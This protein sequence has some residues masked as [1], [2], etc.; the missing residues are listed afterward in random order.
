MATGTINGVKY[1]T[2]ANY[3]T[4]GNRWLQFKYSTSIVSPGKTKVTWTLK[5]MYDGSTS[6]RSLLTNYALRINGEV[7]CTI[8]QANRRYVSYNNGNDYSGQLGEPVNE[9][10][11]FTVTHN[12]SGEGKFTIK[13]T[14]AI[15]SSTSQEVSKTI[16]LPTNYPYTACGAPTSIKI[17][18]DETDITSGYFNTATTS[19]TLS[20]S[21]AKAG[22]ANSIK[23]YKVYYTVNGTPTL[24]SSSVTVNSTS[25]EGS[26]TITLPENMKNGQ[27]IKFAIITLGSAGGDYN[28]GFSSSK[29]SATKNTPPS[30]P[31]ISVN[32]SIVP[33]SGGTVTFTIKAG[34]D[35]QGHS[36]KLYYSTSSNESGIE[37]SGSLTTSTITESITYY[38]WSNDGYDNS[39]KVSKTITINTKPTIEIIQD[40]TGDVYDS[41]N[42]ET[43]ISYF[44]GTIQSNKISGVNYKWEIIKDGITTQIGTNSTIAFKPWTKGIKPGE[45]YQVKATINDG[46]ESNSVIT[47]ETFTIPANASVKYVYN[48]WDG[49]S[50][51]DGTNGNMFSTKLKV[52]LPNDTVFQ[53]ASNISIAITADNYI[54][55]ASYSQDIC[56]ITLPTN[57]TPGK[58]YNFKLTLSNNEGL[59]REY[60]F[61]KTKT[62]SF[63]GGDLQIGNNEIKIFPPLQTTTLNFSIPNPEYTY[64]DTSYNYNLK[65]SGMVLYFNNNYNYPYSIIP[66]S[67]LDTLIFNFTPEDWKNIANEIGIIDN[68][69]NIQIPLEL[70]I[71]N[72]FEDTVSYFG[73]CIFNMQSKVN[74]NSFNVNLNNEV[75]DGN[76]TSIREG[77]IFNW[78][79]N[80][81]SYNKQSIKSEIFICRKNEN[82]QPVEDDNNWVLYI[83]QQDSLVERDNTYLINSE[84]TQ[85]YTI[86]EISTSNYIFF[87]LRII[88]TYG[89]ITEEIIE[90]GRSNRHIKPQFTIENITYSENE[91]YFN[92][93]LIDNGGGI[94]GNSL[95]NLKNSIELEKENE[96]EDGVI[97]DLSPEELNFSSTSQE[98][99]TNITNFESTVLHL[100]LKLKTWLEIEDS[101]NSKIFKEQTYSFIVYNTAPTIA[102]RKN[103]V[104]INQKTFGDDEVVVISATQERYNFILK[105]AD[106]TITINL[107]NGSIT[108]AEITGAIIN[109][110]VIDGGTW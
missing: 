40:I 55:V 37:F 33:S 58:E 21:G 110:C 25:T 53:E 95:S 45:S 57:L 15:Y 4:S 19:L 83:S 6:V 42:G 32:K 31:T 35:A 43:F 2:S 48:Q 56:Y 85:S 75:L 9:S 107:K 54:G 41:Y 79:Y 16:T 3:S 81:S 59:T 99:L 100:Q 61:S 69:N 27:Y 106:K 52:G 96:N 11:S 50:N 51:I 98:I 14:S 7:K 5:S 80:L 84:K 66:E 10:G 89:Q 13:L 76:S 77:Q 70:R 17:L 104:G 63:P 49:N 109:N 64:G 1:N 20:W 73:N 46:I 67:T 72:L 30:A 91:L 105:G 101:E 94:I 93:N 29:P 65:E 24:S 47:E 92:I 90:A 102:V 26:T 68:I 82:I 22:T 8:T 103:H 97:G 108:G 18:K 87:K 86:P 28:S 62:Y 71:T 34:S 39:D 38:F 12:S 74:I 36:Q 78:K 60:N 44:K 23:G 88:D